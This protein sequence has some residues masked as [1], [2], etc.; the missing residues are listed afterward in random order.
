MSV[1][2]ALKPSPLFVSHAGNLE[3]VVLN[4]VFPQQTGFFVD[5]GAS[6]PVN[7]SNT[8][9]LYKRGWSGITIEPS[10]RVYAKL[11]ATRP[12]DI[13]LGVAVGDAEGEASFFQFGDG[14]GHST[15]DRE[16]AQALQREIGQQ[17][18]EFKVPVRTL[19]SILAEYAA[20]VDIDVVCIDA[21]GAEAAILRGAQLQRFRPKLIIIEAMAAFLQVDVSQEASNILEQNGYVL[22][23]EDGLNKF[24]VAKE[25]DALLEALRYPPNIFDHYITAR[26]FSLRR[27]SRWRLRLLQ[28]TLLGWVLSLVLVL[29]AIYRMA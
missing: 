8:W 16:R 3:D 26:E 7:G 22:G 4:R 10:P 5:V 29:T 13:C 6:D 15:C 20:G 28:L 9:A 23:Y 18:T 2:S 24:F 11:K 14:A 1:R 12:R 17:V 25:H 21:E 19:G 27:K